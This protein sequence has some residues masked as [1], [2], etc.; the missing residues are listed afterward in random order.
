MTS[1]VS[2][3]NPISHRY[4]PVVGTREL[5]NKCTPVG[6]ICDLVGKN[7]YP[8]DDPELHRKKGIMPKTCPNSPIEKVGLVYKYT[9]VG[10]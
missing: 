4:P 7:V 9:L 3:D 1:H 6:G 2:T 10:V 5:V 8:L